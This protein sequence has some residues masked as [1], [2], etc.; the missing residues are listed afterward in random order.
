[1]T[2]M[3]RA[4]TAN[5]VNHAS[6]VEIVPNGPLAA[7]HRSV[8]VSAKEITCSPFMVMLSVIISHTDNF[9]GQFYRPDVVLT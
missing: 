4:T 3:I 5:T 6:D 7:F 9:I 8:G 1:M 2:D